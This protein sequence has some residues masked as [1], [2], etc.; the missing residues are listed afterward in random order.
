MRGI[1]RGDAD[2]TVR[3]G[4]VNAKLFFEDSRR[5]CKSR[6]RVRSRRRMWWSG[7]VHFTDFGSGE[8]FLGLDTLRK[9]PTG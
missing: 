1:S 4:Q 8:T 6:R 5:K 2:V 9:G 7:D 3:N